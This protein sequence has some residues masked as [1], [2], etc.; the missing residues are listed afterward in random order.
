MPAMRRSIAIILLIALLPWQA[1]GWAATAISENASGALHVIAHWSGEAHHHDGHDEGFHQDDSEES[2]QHAVHSDAHL[3]AVALLPLTM[4]W[5]MP[6]ADRAAPENFKPGGHPGP[7]L[8]GPRR[9]PRS[10][11]LIA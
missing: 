5:A 8:E 4:S 11:H 10:T 2:I 1:V 3:N 7:Y 9:P 6:A